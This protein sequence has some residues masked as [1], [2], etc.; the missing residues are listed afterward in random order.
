MNPVRMRPCAP[1]IKRSFATACVGGDKA[2]KRDQLWSRLRLGQDV[3]GDGR[4]PLCGEASRSTVLAQYSAFFG[5][6]KSR[7]ITSALLTI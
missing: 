5:S 1:E 2:M 3:Q 4:A 6:D 7:T